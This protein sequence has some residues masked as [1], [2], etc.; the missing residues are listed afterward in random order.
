M[1][2]GMVKCQYPDHYVKGRSG[3]MLEEWIVCAITLVRIVHLVV[4]YYIWSSP[5]LGS[6][7]YLLSTDDMLYCSSIK[8]VY[9]STDIMLFQ[10]WV[11]KFG[12][13]ACSISSECEEEPERSDG[14][15][16]YT[17]LHAWCGWLHVICMQVVLLAYKGNTYMCKYHSQNGFCKNLCL[18]HSRMQHSPRDV[19][20]IWSFWMGGDMVKWEGWWLYSVILSKTHLPTSCLTSSLSKHLHPCNQINGKS[21]HKFFR[22]F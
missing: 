20:T 11:C 1:W 15:H 12:N 2:F 13:I 16:K 4:V 9:S 18:F 17:R 19:Q 6:I 8:V 7:M 3:K 10:N 22:R 21:I 5:Y 14:I